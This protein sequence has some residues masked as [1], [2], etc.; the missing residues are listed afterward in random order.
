MIKFLRLVAAVAGGIIF[1]ITESFYWLS[2]NLVRRTIK[3]PDRF[4]LGL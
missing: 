1:P 4:N 3:I 2:V